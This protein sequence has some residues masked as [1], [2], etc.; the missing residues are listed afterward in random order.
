MKSETEI[1][2]ELRWFEDWTNWSSK[3]NEKYETK[4]TGKTTLP[5]YVNEVRKN[6]KEIYE[7]FGIEN[8]KAKW[9]QHDFPIEEYEKIK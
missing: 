1:E 8:Y 4:I 7:E 9:I 2:Y 5:K 3:N 6:L